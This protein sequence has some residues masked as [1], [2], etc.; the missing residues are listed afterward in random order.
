V[1]AAQPAYQENNSIVRENTFQ[2]AYRDA[3][4]RARETLRTRDIAACCA[5]A[6]ALLHRQIDTAGIIKLCFLNSTLHITLPDLLFGTETEKEEISLWEQILVLH[7]LA[8]SEKA[9]LQNTLINYRRLRDGALYA[10]PFERRCIEPLLATFGSVPEELIAASSA[11]G[12]TQADLADVSVR[13]PAFPRLDIICCLWKP[14]DEFGPEATILFDAGAEQFLCAEDIA[15]L[16]QQ[17]VLKLI[18][19]RV[20]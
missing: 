20:S 8:N 10:E 5:K 11:L 19:T 9:G 6:G 13:I 3:L 18:K 7:Y 16:C 4:H 12:G 15:V 14:D 2:T 17:I 1:E